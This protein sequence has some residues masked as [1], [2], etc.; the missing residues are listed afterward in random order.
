MSNYRKGR[1]L[2]H[3]ARRDLEADGYAVVRSAGSKGA[4]DLVATCPRHILLIQVKAEGRTRP[5]DIEK[6]RAVP[7]P[8]RGVYK[9]IWER[10]KGAWR[11]TRLKRSE[12]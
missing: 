2:E 6:L 10:H 9:E 5:K 11:I 1:Y 12:P 7:A 3:L 4:V 8:K